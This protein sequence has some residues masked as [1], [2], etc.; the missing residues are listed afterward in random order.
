MR[1]TFAAALGFNWLVGGTDGHAKNYSILHGAGGRVRLAPF[2]DLASVLPYE[3]FADADLK[4]SMKYGRTYRL[5]AIDREAWR[6]VARELR[7]RP[8]ELLRRLRQMAEA[9]PERVQAIGAQV[10]ADG[11]HFP[12]VDRLVDVLARRALFC[13]AVLGGS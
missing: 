13:L 3:G 9:L 12:V 2:Y 1:W 8:E 6:Q 10:V 7:L 5:A 4:L 11:F